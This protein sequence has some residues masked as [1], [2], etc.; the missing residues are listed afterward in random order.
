MA[1]A[2][3]IRGDIRAVLRQLLISSFQ[4]HLFTHPAGVKVDV[5]VAQATHALNGDVFDFVVL[6]P[7]HEANSL[8]VI[9]IVHVCPKHCWLCHLRK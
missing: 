7:D 9:M 6:L 4:I 5:R 8:L 3:I 1:D 2:N